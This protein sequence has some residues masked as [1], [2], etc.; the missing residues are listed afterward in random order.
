MGNDGVELVRREDRHLV[1]A[2]RVHCLDFERGAAEH[3][4]ALLGVGEH[5]ADDAVLGDLAGASVGNPAANLPSAVIRIAFEP[6]IPAFSADTLSH[7]YST[8]HV[9][10]RAIGTRD[11]RNIL[12]ALAFL[13]T[14]LMARRTR[15]RHDCLINFLPHERRGIYPGWCD[16]EAM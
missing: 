14:L 2:S 1:V 12:P 11:T 8:S 4:A 5:H 6:S 3:V 16:E 10:H 9:F 13:H 15:A 7:N